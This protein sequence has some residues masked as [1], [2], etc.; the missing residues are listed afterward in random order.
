MAKNTTSYQRTGNLS[1]ANSK[2]DNMWGGSNCLD[3][4]LHRFQLI[5]PYEQGMLE[6]CS[7]CG[8]EEFFTVVEGRIDNLEYLYYHARQALPKQHPYFKHEYQTI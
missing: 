1:L 4:W 8:Q 2:E 6:R 5:K 3:S 7:I